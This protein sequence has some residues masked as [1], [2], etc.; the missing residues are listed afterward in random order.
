MDV[1]ILNK[2]VRAYNGRPRE[3]R[4][5]RFWSRVY[6]GSESGCWDWLAH[7]T[8]K[9]YGGFRIGGKEIQ[10]HRVSWII[11]NGEIPKDTSGNTL[12]VLHKC[13]NPQ[14]T[15]PDHL[16]LGTNADNMMDRDNKGRQANHEGENSNSSKLTEAEVLEIRKIYALGRLSQI[17][18]AKKY[19]VNNRQVSNIVT[20]KAWKHI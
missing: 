6:K 13:D 18:I 14:C 17:K 20:R 9:G 11:H 1:S 19:S 8:A 15:N 7:R 2:N 12:H 16:F 3:T 5:N 4:A 10:A